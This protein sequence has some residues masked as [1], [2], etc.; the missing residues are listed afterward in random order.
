VVI[1]AGRVIDGTGRS[2]LTEATIVI[3]GEKI[4]AIDGT[5]RLEVPTGA[6]IIDA[7]GKT[8]IPGLIDMHVHYQEW[9]DRLFLRHGVTTVRDVGNNLEAILTQRQWSQQPGAVRP[10]LFACGPLID[11]PQPFWG[12]WISRSVTTVDE[13][14][15]TAR[16]L[17]ERKVDCLKAYVKLTPPQ[18]HALVDVASAHGVPVTAHVQATT[19]KEAIALGVKSLEHASGVNYLSV[20]DEELHALA[21]LITTKGVFVVPT[22]VVNEQ[23]SRLLT[24]DIRQEPLLQHV[25]S[26]FFGWW[27]APYGVGQ[28]TEAHSTRCQ[29]ILSRQQAFIRMLATTNGRIVAG[30][31]T[32]NPYVLPGAGLL[33]ELE[34][35]VASGLTPAQA[36]AAATQVAADLLGQE[37][38]LGTLTPG[39]IADLVILDGNPLEDIGQIRRVEMALRD[40]RIVWPPAPGVPVPASVGRTAPGVPLPGNVAIVSPAPAVSQEL[41]TFSGTWIGA[42]DSILPHVLV[43]E[44]ID[45]PQALV[46][47]AWGVVPERQIPPP[48]WT[49]LRGEFVDGTLKV[50]LP[51]PATVFYR[52]Q[53]DG[54]LHATY[55]WHGGRS[56][57]TMT[58]VQE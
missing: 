17:V 30:S 57:A 1:H 11:G 21:S 46:V 6:T 12:P 8:V 10:R 3:T 23:L 28:W 37:A 34:L 55:E 24:P 26:H 52:M 40:G 22:L 49:R 13:A 9:M 2:P 48:G 15:Q 38:H 44:E 31:D 18:L 35:L 27:E 14:H 39:K 7:R 53:P 5:E 16:E 47:Y 41:A 36:I 58:R 32:P 4:T 25:P 45:L 43:V 50:S 29:R 51:R 54:T 33:R 56:Q 42:W 20:T 19:A